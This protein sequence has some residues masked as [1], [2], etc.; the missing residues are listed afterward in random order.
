MGLLPTRIASVFE[1]LSGRELLLYLAFERAMRSLSLFFNHDISR[2]TYN[3]TVPESEYP[4]T[5]RFNISDRAVFRQIF[6]DREYAILDKGAAPEYIID[7]G[8]Y[9]GYSSAY[10]LSRFPKA[11]VI[12]I[13]PDP[14][15]FALLQHN[16]A[17]FGERATVRHAAIWSHPAALV[18]RRGQYRDGLAWST[19]IGEV[20]P[21]EQPDINAIDIKTLMR[22]AGFPR[23]DVLKMDI[24]RAEIEVFSRNYS[25]WID[26]VNTFLIEL[27]DEECRAAFFA[28]L[29]QG[30]FRFSEAG[31]LTIAQR[32]T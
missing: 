12:A 1:R 25:S 26:K 7:C 16:L 27:H 21:G 14:E 9:A 15:N 17:P 29:P 28:A 6:I 24:E 11:K 31:E 20:R 22:E 3:L 5:C 18:V 30:Q 19:Q 10:F 23:I 4:L 13:E 8:A 32:T 2:R